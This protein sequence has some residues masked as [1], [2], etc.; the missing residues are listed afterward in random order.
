M[1][2]EP[3]SKSK[4]WNWNAIK[5]QEWE[6]PAREVYPV[7]NR[8]KL[9]GYK[10]VLDLGCGVG[11]HSILLAENGFDVYA[12]DLSQQGIDRLNKIIDK[13]KLKIKT[14]VS[15]M[16]DIPY[17]L[18]YF[19][20]VIAF[21]S[22]YHTDDEGIK[23]TINN[24]NRVLKI[25]GEALVTFNSKN[26]WSFKNSDNFISA[27]SIMKTSGHE[28]GIPHFYA[29]KK[30]I[31]GLLKNFEI[32]KFWYTEEYLPNDI[33]TAHYFTLIRKINEFKPE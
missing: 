18:E 26:S 12:C 2:N 5:D 16:L 32:E 25:G 19:D 20:A 11:R 9:K 27:N 4:S 8:W 1:K 23:R 3:Q 7:V 30:D 28:S 15:D 24:I 22:I 6:E 33:Y 29:D 10:K 13:S 21:R 17:D 31:E 14:E